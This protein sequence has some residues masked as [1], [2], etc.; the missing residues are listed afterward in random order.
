M[1]HSLYF[2]ITI[3]FGLNFLGCKAIENQN[4]VPKKITYKT[5]HKQE[6]DLHKK[7]IT[8]MVYSKNL[9]SLWV[10]TKTD[11]EPYLF[12][13]NPA[14]GKTKEKVF[15]RSTSLGWQGISNHENTL[16]I[17]DIGDPKKRRRNIQV[18][19]ISEREIREQFAV[20]SMK[21]FSYPK[22]KK[23]A[24][25][26]VYHPTMKKFFI[27]TYGEEKTEIYSVSSKLKKGTL[28]KVGELP[29]AEVTDVHLSDDLSEIMIVT[30]SEVSVFAIKSDKDIL[31]TI[32]DGMPIFHKKLNKCTFKSACFYGEKNA[33][34]L[35]VHNPRHD[36]TY[37]TLEQKEGYF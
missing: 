15:V 26:M 1:K 6:L 8:G 20:P 37:Y 9:K 25:A 14:T 35:L 24:K 21:T 7:N 19:S 31:T 12:L 29:I 22:S 28:E 27:F 34:C 18:L 30:N 32:E 11:N 4:E 16:H 2:I 17:G 33:L 23:D 13:I 10:Q 36:K 5:I 3:S